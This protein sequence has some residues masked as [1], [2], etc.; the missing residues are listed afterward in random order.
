[1]KQSRFCVLGIN[2]ES[3][4]SALGELGR[5]SCGFEPVFF[6]FLHTGVAGEVA[7]SFERGAVLIRIRLEQRTGDAMADSA[8]LSG[9]AAA[10]NGALHVELTGGAR[11]LERLTA[12][13]FQCLKAEVVIDSTIVYLDIAGAARIQ[14][15]TRN[16]GFPSARAVE[17]SLFRCIH[18]LIP[19]FYLS[20]FS[21]FCA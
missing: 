10:L 2:T 12:Y 21:G 19:P 8:S 20:Q 9:E 14:T 11:S 5:T 6:A 7:G 4:S 16:G 17:L 13:H 15:H 18:Q 3:R 1:M